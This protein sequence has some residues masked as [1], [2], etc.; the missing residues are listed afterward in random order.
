M[1]LPQ[2]E[3]NF[4]SYNIHII[5]KKFKFQLSPKCAVE[6]DPRFCFDLRIIHLQDNLK[7]SDFRLG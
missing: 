3:E 6:D 5:W 4:I 2:L 1:N 7:C